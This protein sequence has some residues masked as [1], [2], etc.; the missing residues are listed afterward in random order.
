MD[1]AGSCDLCSASE[2]WFV[3]CDEIIWSR[4]E[5]H[6]GFTIGTVMQGPPQATADLAARITYRA[7]MGFTPSGQR[8]FGKQGTSPRTSQRH[9]KLNE[10]KAEMAGT[11]DHPWPQ[12]VERSKKTKTATARMSSHENK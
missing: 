4:R 8:L 12:F 11:D 6:I 7:A 10:E 2:I 1:F 5:S 3:A 9:F